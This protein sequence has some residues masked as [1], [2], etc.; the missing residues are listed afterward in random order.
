MATTATL[1]TQVLEAQEK[2]LEVIN[3]HVSADHRARLDLIPLDRA[4][5][6]FP[7]Y[8]SALHAELI[9]GLAEIVQ[10]Q[11]QRLSALETPP[12][13]APADA[14]ADG[15]ADAPADA[16]KSSAKYSA[17]SSAKDFVKE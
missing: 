8:L 16:P 1:A 7:E 2:A 13:D 11:G 10:E 9:A 6:K 17:K 14:P 5:A 12:A 3:E 4:H 15:P